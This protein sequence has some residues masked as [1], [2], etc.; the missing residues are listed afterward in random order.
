[1]PRGRAEILPGVGHGPGFQLGDG[2]S[3]AGAAI[4]DRLLAFLDSVESK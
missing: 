2:G 4:N 3:G 1:M